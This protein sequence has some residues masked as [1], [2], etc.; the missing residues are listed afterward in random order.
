MPNRTGFQSFVNN[1][2]PIGVPGDFASVN[3]HAS[4]NGGQ[5]QFVAAPG[6]VNVAVF[7]WFDPSTGLGHNY[8][9]PN[10]FLG[11]VHRENNGLITQ[12]LGI[13]TMQV[14]PG[15]IVTGQEAGEFLGIFAAG[16]SAKQ[17]VYCDPVT[18]A[19]SAAATGGSITGGNTGASVANSVLTTTDADA[20]GTAAAVG[21]IAYNGGLPPG[22]YIAS[23]AG[24]G[25]GTHL[26]NLANV[27]GTAIPNI[28]GPVTISLRGII[29]TNYTT[30]EAVAANATSDTAALAVTGILTIGGTIT[31]TW[32]AGQFVSGAGI[33]GS[34]NMLI[35]YQLPGGTPGG[36]GTYQ[37]SYQPAV[38]I[39][40]EAMVAGQGQV[41]G[42]S[43]WVAAAG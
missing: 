21:M 12:F 42:I 18:G 5:G 26:W 31:G 2:L 36:A 3:P 33:P 7:G 8:Y 14:V 15:N 6:G 9:T 19:L 27:D 20:T 4:V 39:A 35:N 25:S 38:A 29:E 40:N 30:M 22:T 32:E 11:F 41:G 13:A 16:C 28:A 10:S 17:K 24:T 23:A 37:T 43:T 34:A 1:E